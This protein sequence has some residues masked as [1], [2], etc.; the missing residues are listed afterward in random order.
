MYKQVDI[1]DFIDGYRE[2]HTG[3][4]LF[5]QIFQKIDNPMTNCVNCLCQYCTH[6]AE[7]LYHNVKL[8]EAA[9][10]PCFNCDECKA[11]DGAADHNFCDRE[12]CEN[13][14]MSGYGA[15]K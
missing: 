2:N 13:F 8:E 9:E 7:E 11:F 14:I 6:N 4:S 12:D 1:F 10:E 15:E 3:K 5:E